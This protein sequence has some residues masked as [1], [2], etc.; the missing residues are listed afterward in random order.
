[1]LK[2]H[3]EP[4]VLYVGKSKR[5]NVIEQIDLLPKMKI[6]K[7]VIN[8]TEERGR[9]IDPKSLSAIHSIVRTNNENSKKS[10]YL[11][12]GHVIKI[13]D[14][15]ESEG[16]SILNYLTAHQVKPE[17]VY[18]FEWEPD[19]LALWSNYAMLHSPVNDF[20]GLERIMHRITIK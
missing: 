1:M 2:K 15:L 4:N 20:T 6:S 18:E 11:S 5:K 16:T 9:D 10:I 14:V 3:K 19:C 12:P 13:T 7:T 17:F 8:R